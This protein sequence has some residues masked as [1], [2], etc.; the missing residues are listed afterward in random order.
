MAG[1]L[2]Q[3]VPAPVTLVAS[4]KA[5]DDSCVAQH[6]YLRRQL[7]IDAVHNVWS[8]DGHFQRHQLTDRAD[9][10]VS[11][12]AAHPVTLRTPAVPSIQA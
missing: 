10:L 12:S 7:G 4:V 2:M 3:P 6:P 9:A 1:L 8:C 11:A 5:V